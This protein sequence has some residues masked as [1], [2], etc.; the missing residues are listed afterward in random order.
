MAQWV[1]ISMDFAEG[2]RM[3]RMFKLLDDRVTDLRPVFERVAE[4]LGPAIDG[5]AFLPEGPGWQQ[6]APA[7]VEQRRRRI[8]HGEISVGARHPILQQT[9]VLRESLTDRNARGHVESIEHDRMTYGT[10]VPY[11]LVHQDG[12]DD[13]SIPQRKILNA[14]QLAPVVSRVFEDEMTAAV[15]RDISQGRG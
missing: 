1:N 11:A 2:E 4:E 9:G 5:E 12:S 6:L 10:D 15:R 13:G 7:T 14:E 3:D 8:A